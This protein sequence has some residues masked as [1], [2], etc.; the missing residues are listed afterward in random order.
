MKLR[1]TEKILPSGTWFFVLYQKFTNV[2]EEYVDLIFILK[3]QAACSFKTVGN[4]IPEYTTSNPQ[5]QYSSKFPP[6][7]PQISYF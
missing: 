1:N 5:K 4:L 7:E 6:W 2:S 3:M